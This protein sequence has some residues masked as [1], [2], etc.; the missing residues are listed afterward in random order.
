[1]TKRLTFAAC[2]VAF[3]ML[4]GATGAEAII[5]T[6][7]ENLAVIPA[8]PWQDPVQPGPG[9]PTNEFA[10]QGILVTDVYQ[11]VDTRDPWDDVGLATVYDQFFVGQVGVIDFIVP[12]NSLMVDWWIN[13]SATIYVEAYDTS[14]ILVDSFS[15]T[16]PGSLLSGTDTLTG[17][18]ISQMRFFDSGGYPGIS[19]LEFE[20]IPE[21][22]TML[23]LGGLGA[24]LAGA[25][26]LRRKK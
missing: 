12:T 17:S 8:P 13:S 11:Y 19:T 25:K 9:L 22:M 4:L 20:P 7:T 23:M 18:M 3:A 1:M 24:G 16:A 6:F 21:P 5:I 2:A 14:A 15:Y 26:K 10:A